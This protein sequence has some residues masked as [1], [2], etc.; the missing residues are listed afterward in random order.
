MGVVAE[1]LKTEADRLKAEK[2]KRRAV[3][4]DWVTL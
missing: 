1:Y 3:V 2:A 4:R